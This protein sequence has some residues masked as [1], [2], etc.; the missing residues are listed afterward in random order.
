[1]GVHADCTGSRGTWETPRPLPLEGLLPH[2]VSGV[3]GA[4]APAGTSDSGL[5]EGHAALTVGLAF[6]LSWL[7]CNFKSSTI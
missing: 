3:S 5:P 7:P 2:L 6:V 4:P 1:M